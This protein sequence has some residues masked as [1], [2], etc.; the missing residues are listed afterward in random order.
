MSPRVR[1]ARPFESLLHAFRYRLLRVT[2]KVSLSVVPRRYLDDLKRERNMDGDADVIA[3]RNLLPRKMSRRRGSHWECPPADGRQMSDESGGIPA[4]GS[5]SVRKLHSA[6]Y[7]SRRRKIIILR[8]MSGRQRRE[9]GRG[10]ARPFDR[11][12]SAVNLARGPTG[13]YAGHDA[14]PLH[15]RLLQI[16]LTF[17][18]FR[19]GEH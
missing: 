2:V 11:S 8:V 15:L 18:Y 16:D 7:F 6:E 13:A 10:R 4:S 1:D 14:P 3:L 5:A 9:R 12:T 19:T 17:G